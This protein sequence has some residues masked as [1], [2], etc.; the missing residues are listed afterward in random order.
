MA[1]PIKATSIVDKRGP[2]RTTTSFDCPYCGRR[3]DRD[4]TK[5]RG[6][7]GGSAEGFIWSGMRNHVFKC[8]EIL[9][10]QAGYALASTGGELG[11]T[12]EPVAGLEDNEANRRFLRGIKAAIAK[13]RRDG[14]T[15][16]VPE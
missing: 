5:R 6:R 10:Y 9:L 2:I 14:H 3:T 16:R 8:W 4:G 1:K 15:P 7:G 12:V 11:Y 13:R